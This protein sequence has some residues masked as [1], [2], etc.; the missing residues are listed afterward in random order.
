MVHPRVTYLLLL[1]SC[2]HR[3]GEIKKAGKQEAGKQESIIHMGAKVFYYRVL[4][5]LQSLDKAYR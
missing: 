5:R 4:T 2:R 3:P 1:Q